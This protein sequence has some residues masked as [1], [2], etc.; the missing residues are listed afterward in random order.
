M[1]AASLQDM[2]YRGNLAAAEPCALPDLFALAESGDPV[3]HVAP[4][5]QGRVLPIIPTVLP[6]GSLR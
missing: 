2:D 5:D 6:N 3:P 4:I 1:T